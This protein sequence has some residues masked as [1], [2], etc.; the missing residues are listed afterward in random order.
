MLPMQMLTD[1]QKETICYFFGIGIGRPKGLEDIGIKFDHTA[2]RVCKI[3]DKAINKLR[4]TNIINPLRSY[5]NA[6]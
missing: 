1:R 3:K 4:T 5:L 6:S 2:E